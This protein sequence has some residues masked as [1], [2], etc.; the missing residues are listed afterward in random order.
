MKIWVITYGDGFE[1]SGVI[2]EAY[3][4]KTTADLRCLELNDKHIESGHIYGGYDVQEFELNKRNES[5]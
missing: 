4:D 5:L 1:F 3:D 2:Y